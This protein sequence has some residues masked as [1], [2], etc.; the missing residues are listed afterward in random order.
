[1]KKRILSIILTLALCLSLLPTAAL[2]EDNTIPDNIT[3]PSQTPYTIAANTKQNILG[4]EYTASA[5]GATVVLAR[6][7]AGTTA[8]TYLVVTAGSITCSLSKPVGDTLFS[9]TMGYQKSEGVYEKDKTFANATAEG[10]DSSSIMLT[11]SEDGNVAVTL[12]PMDAVSI[13]DV[14]Y[15]RMG[16]DPLTLQYAPGTGVRVNSTSGAL[17]VTGANAT[18][19]LNGYDMGSGFTQAVFEFGENATTLTSGSVILTGGNS[20]T[21]NGNAYTAASTDTEISTADG[22]TATLKAGS[23]VLEQD[24]VITA[25]GTEYTASTGGAIINLD[26]NTVSLTSGSV[27]L[28]QGMKI[29]VGDKN[30]EYT[31]ASDGTVI[32]ING[33][34]GA[35]TTGELKKGSVALME[36]HSIVIDGKQYTAD[37]NDDGLTGGEVTVVIEN[38]LA[39]VSG[40]GSLSYTEN[41]A[42]ITIDSDGKKLTAGSTD[43]AEGETIQVTGVQLSNGQWV[44]GPGTV[45]INDEGSI[46]TLTAT[47]AG[48]AKFGPTATLGV[49]AQ[50]SFPVGST[51][52]I[53]TLTAGSITLPQAEAIKIGEVTYRAAENNTIIDS[54]GTVSAGSVTY[55]QNGSTF[56]RTSSDDILGAGTVTLAK[57]ESVKIGTASAYKTY[58]AATAGTQISIDSEGAVK[59][60]AG[61]LTLAAGESI[62][63]NGGLTVENTAEAGDS[64]TVTVTMPEVENGLVKVETA[65]NAQ[66]T[67]PAQTSFIVNEEV[68]CYNPDNEEAVFNITTGKVTTGTIII[69]PGKSYTTATNNTYENPETNKNN[70]WL[71]IENGIFLYGSGYNYEGDIPSPQVDTAI[72]N[73]LTYTVAADS[74]IVIAPTYFMLNGV[75]TVTVPDDPEDEEDRSLTAK[76]VGSNI[77]STFSLTAGETKFSCTQGDLGITLLSGSVTLEN[78]ASYDNAILVNGYMIAPELNLSVT[79][80]M[81]GG[82]AKVTTESAIFMSLASTDTDNIGFDAGSTDPDSPVV[83]IAAPAAGETAGAVTLLDGDFKVPKSYEALTVTVGNDVL[84]LT[85]DVEIGEAYIGYYDGELIL[86]SGTVS[87]INTDSTIDGITLDAG[88]NAEYTVDCDNRILTLTENGSLTVTLPDKGEYIFYGATASY[89]NASN[90]PTSVNPKAKYIAGETNVTVTFTKDDNTHSFTTSVAKENVSHVGASG[91]DPETVTIGTM[92]DTPLYPEAIADAEKKQ[93]V[94]IGSVTYT[95][96][97]PDGTEDNVITLS[98]GSTGSV[99]ANGPLTSLKIDGNTALNVGGEHIEVIGTAT[100]YLDEDGVKLTAGKIKLAAGD[101]IYAN[102]VNVTGPATVTINADGTASVD[103]EKNAGINAQVVQSTAAKFTI[104]EPAQDEDCGTVILNSGKI[105]GGAGTYVNIDADTKVEAGMS[106]TIEVNGNECT[107]STAAGAAAITKAG[108]QIL[109]LDQGNGATVTYN[110]ANGTATLTSSKLTDVTIPVTTGGLTVTPAE[111]TTYSISAAGSGDCASLV[112]SAGGS[113]EVTFTQSGVAL[114]LGTS[115][116][117]YDDGNDTTEDTINVGEVTSSGTGAKITVTDA[118]VSGDSLNVTVDEETNAVTAVAQGATGGGGGGGGSST[119]TTTIKNED[120]STTTTTTNKATGTVT[121]T[122]KKTDGSSTTVETKK[123]GTVTTTEKTASGITGTVVTDKN[124]DV[125]E[126]SA[127]VPTAAVKEAE[128]TGEAVTLPVEVPAAATIE[129]APA[130]EVNVPASVDSVKVEIPVE[131]VTSGTVAVIVH[132][133]GT[134]E[135]VKTSTVSDTGVV[136]TLNSDATIKVI[137]NSKEFS[138]VSD[139]YW[140]MDAIDFV[141]AREIYS[142]TSATTFHPDNTMTRGMLAVVLHRLENTPDHNYTGSFTDVAVDSWYEDAIHWAADNGIVG[143]YGNGLYGPNDNITREQLAVMLWRYAGS[144]DSSHGLSHFVD[145]DQ[146]SNYARAALTWANEN[147]IINGKGNNI[148][149]PKGDATRAQV[150]QMLKN[151]LCSQSN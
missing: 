129:D 28:A 140:A 52:G 150:A 5:D 147:G 149:D 64:G 123:D 59:L 126:A 3:E 34:T 82:V 148:L 17:S 24:A 74:A 8:T 93:S 142:G 23:V 25:N 101:S 30:T 75:L 58:T 45:A 36:G 117:T 87:G 15:K 145:A 56:T 9:V 1:M 76:V 124:G 116:L 106:G 43:L 113:A 108:T 90:V 57:G 151:Y 118:T 69:E 85:P 32:G 89:T 144:P 99:L 80:T 114:A 60:K 121:E 111:S 134:E 125:I 16:N 65:N 81:T 10:Q 119:T 18:N 72:V 19:I 138:D 91:D 11:L 120:G 33:A 61:S 53:A 83:S 112:V 41:G 31:A 133:D 110:K 63:A 38:G 73:G 6:E 27:K 84:T 77:D 141:V 139:S 2:A 97:T 102:G 71:D 51:S 66:I 86:Y 68:A 54:A 55:T 35:G 47:S 42:T 13:G 20:I 50:I 103:A 107:V 12:A 137:D 40:P 143:G 70:L 146:I 130:V 122:T 127:T 115:G 62:T 37:D 88:S 14:T 136:V 39:K 96:V 92:T 78:E 100:I 29:Y 44:T 48:G 49:S 7:G 105:T 95:N 109:A 104:T 21:V 67:V 132:A 131:N 22:I 26:S 79:V 98:V 128:K 46:A 135:I 94:T 4:I